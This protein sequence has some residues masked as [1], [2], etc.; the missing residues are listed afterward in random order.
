MNARPDPDRPDH[1]AEDDAWRDLVARL[2]GGVAEPGEDGPAPAEPSAAERSAGV[3]RGTAPEGGAAPPFDAFDPLG[4]SRRDPAGNAEHTGRT[5]RGAASDD[6]D[7]AGDM[8]PGDFVPE[9][10]EP[11]LAGADPAVVL[12][13]C[14]ALGGPVALLLCALLWRGVPGYVV[15][16]LIAAFLAG[17]GVLIMRLPRHKDDGDDGARV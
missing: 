5:G 17:V 1:A 12:A 15:A 8:L 10:P 4:V 3:Q 9:E 7:A 13:W 14:G 11:V 6:S 2:R 16:L